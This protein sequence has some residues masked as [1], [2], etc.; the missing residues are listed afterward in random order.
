MK[1]MYFEQFRDFCDALISL[2]FRGTG[3]KTLDGAFHCRA[4]H[5]LH[6]RNADAVYPLMV[7][8][9]RTGDTKYLDAAKA[10]FKWGENLVCDDGA[11]LNDA[12]NPWK[13][14]TVFAA[15]ATCEALNC[16]G[17]LLDSATRAAWEDRL[18]GMG[19]WLYSE[20]DENYHAN[21]NYPVT[22][23]AALAL[24]G[25]YFGREEYLKQARHLADYAMERITENGFLW[26]EGKPR[27]FVSPLGCRPVDMGYNLEESLP[28]LVKYAYTVGNEDMLDQL[29]DVLLKQLDFMLPDG[30][31][32]NSFG[33]RNNKWTYWGS[34]TSDGCA[35]AFT[36]LAA[37]N[38]VFAEAARRNTELVRACTYDGLLYGGPH[39]RR[40]DEHPCTHHTFEHANAI[41]FA[42]EHTKDMPARSIA[43]P[44]DN[45]EPLKYYPEINVYKLAAGDYRATVTGYDFNVEAGKQ[46]SG[47]TLSLVW[48]YGVGPMIAASVTDYV[49]V[50]HHNM[51]LP[52]A[53]SKHRS[54]TPRLEI[55]KD[56]IA[57]STAYFTA[58]KM[59]GEEKN[60]QVTVTAV[61]GLCDKTLHRLEGDCDREY[62]YTLTE[63]GM[64]ITVT[65][66]EGAHLI[67]PVISGEV[68]MLRGSVTACQDIFF[69]TGGFMADE[70]TVSPDGDGVI[71]L[72]LK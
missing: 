5:V 16:G 39:Y 28:A 11:V 10:V 70:Y 67:L 24:I 57:Y 12:Q 19:K 13:G 17:D 8:A 68:Q 64:H 58:P 36:L 65:H 49:L 72:I 50:E 41:A 59:T 47:G 22:N 52:R 32:D 62:T 33:T 23:A 44:C 42:L 18:R 51:Q 15:I 1:T 45:A 3:D 66:A 4:C 55:K 21:I 63:S 46:A 37:R 14:I 54:L 43:L 25:K 31:W 38:P 20:L 60:G 71:E 6:G 48:K 34:R 56:G 53:T 61:T 29:T 2:Q 35:S 27:D 7:M 26:G 9:K 30:A 40:H 69:L